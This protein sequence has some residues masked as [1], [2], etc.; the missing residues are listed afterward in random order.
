MSCHGPNGTGNILTCNCSPSST[1][2]TRNPQAS[3]NSQLLAGVLEA[4]LVARSHLGYV[5]TAT[6]TNGGRAHDR[7]TLVVDAKRLRDEA[8]MRS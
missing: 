8:P 6:E 3:N 5:L 4:G 2:S 7:L 1:A